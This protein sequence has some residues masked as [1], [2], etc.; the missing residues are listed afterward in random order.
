MGNQGNLLEI[1]YDRVK[2]SDEVILSEENC[3]F[4][5]YVAIEKE[6]YGKT[7]ILFYKEDDPN[8]KTLDYELKNDEAITKIT[9]KEYNT[10]IHIAP[11][12]SSFQ[13]QFADVDKEGSGRNSLT[14]QM[15][16]ERIGY[17]F[18][19]NLTW[20]LIPNSVEYNNWYKILTH[21]PP[22]FKA[23]LLMPSGEIEEKE[24]YRTDI[25][26]ELYLWTDGKQIWKGLSTSFV[27]FD[28]SEYNDTYEPELEV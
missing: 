28:V 21:L 10:Y 20:D 22:S 13:I 1:S 17:Y 19:V 15:Y 25:S 7:Y 27:Q 14:G 2:S 18:S 3:S 12:C 11:P 9:H 24:V 16:R 23:R 5:G 8:K 6:V 26:T 4:Y